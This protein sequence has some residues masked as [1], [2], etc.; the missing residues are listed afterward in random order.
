MLKWFR[1]VST[2]NNAEN[3]QQQQQ[4]RSVYSLQN[5]HQQLTGTIPLSPLILVHAFY[6]TPC[7]YLF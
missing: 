4:A 7:V 6:Q 5:S 1:F 3:E 2:F